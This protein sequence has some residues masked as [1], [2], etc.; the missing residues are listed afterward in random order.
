MIKHLERK[1]NNNFFN[2]KRLIRLSKPR[3]I[4]VR[5]EA[6]SKPTQPLSLLTSPDFI[7][8]LKLKFKLP[9]VTSK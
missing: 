3:R 8:N 7:N 4:F 2:K 1:E 9:N 6:V 5:D